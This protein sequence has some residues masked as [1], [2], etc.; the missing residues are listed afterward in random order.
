MHTGMLSFIL[1][2][3]PLEGKKYRD[4]ETLVQM[5]LLPLRV[6]HSVSSRTSRT[7]SVLICKMG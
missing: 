5:P 1:G 3:Y 7:L 6:W 4:Q 2:H